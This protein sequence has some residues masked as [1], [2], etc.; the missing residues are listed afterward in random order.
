MSPPAAVEVALRKLLSPGAGNAPASLAAVGRGELGEGWFRGLQV[1]SPAS[2]S[3]AVRMQVGGQRAGPSARPATFCRFAY[4]AAFGYWALS[5][6][7]CTE[8]MG[9]DLNRLYHRAKCCTATSRHEITSI[10]IWAPCREQLP[11]EIFSGIN[12]SVL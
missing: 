9:R 10:M 1:N 11:G 7:P 2:R 4:S 8:A 5:T 12:S 3:P 6:A